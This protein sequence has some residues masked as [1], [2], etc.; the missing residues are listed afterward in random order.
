[1][2]SY[3]SRT[4]YEENLSPNM[5]GFVLSIFAGLMFGWLGIN[6]I[7]GCGEVTRT[8]DGTYLKGECVL[9]PW[10]DATLYDHFIE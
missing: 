7:T 4:A 3:Q 1:M 5:R 9:V 2:N 10:V 8:V 6:W